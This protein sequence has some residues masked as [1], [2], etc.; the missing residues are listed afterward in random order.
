MTENKYKVQWKREKKGG[1]IAQQEVIIFGE[2]NV[3][4]FMKSYP[5][6]TKE[7]EVILVV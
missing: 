2:E 4:H 7:V 6:G 3:S 1:H 5:F